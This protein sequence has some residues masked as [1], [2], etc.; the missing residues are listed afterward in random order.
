MHETD[1]SPAVQLIR[2]AMNALEAQQARETFQFHFSCKR[3]GID[4]G[5]RYHVLADDATVMA[6]VGLHHYFWGPAEKVW[7]AWFA[8]DPNHQS[9]GL[10]TYLLDIISKQ[11]KDDGYM[12]LLIETYSTPDFARARA[13][14]EARGFALTGSVAHYLPCGG[15]MLVYAKELTS[16]V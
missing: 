16:H 15:D 13:F 12:T 11:A 4:D 6:I 7:L 2:Q 9:R 5:R 1:I 10:G 8:V 14:Y 3:H